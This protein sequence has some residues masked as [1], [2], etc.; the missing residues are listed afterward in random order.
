MQVAG[1]RLERFLRTEF[2]AVFA[3][4]GRNAPAL[5]DVAMEENCAADQIDIRIRFE[6]GSERRGC[7]DLRDFRNAWGG[8]PSRYWERRHPQR[9]VVHDAQ[10]IYSRE[11]ENWMMNQELRVHQQH[12]QELMRVCT[13]PDVIHAHI[14]EYQQRVEHT[15]RHHSP[16]PSYHA[17][18]WVTGV[19]P[20][21][22][23]EDRTLT[24]QRLMADCAREYPGLMRAPVPPPDQY[25]TGQYFTVPLDYAVS[26]VVGSAAANE[27][28][29]QLLLANLTQKQKDDYKRHGYFEVKGGD[30]G[31]TYR[32]RHGRQMNI[33]ELDAG[34]N[35]VT[36]WCFLPQG[37]LCAG[38]C[39]LAQKTA[40]ELYERDALRIANRIGVQGWGAAPTH[41]HHIQNPLREGA[42]SPYLGMNY[43]VDE[44]MRQGVV[45]F[46]SSSWGA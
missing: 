20:A 16:P 9:A 38:D 22:S 34:G 40:L 21:G 2:A 17:D 36:G 39:M 24:A 45:S 8:R 3:E 14:T 23:G 32:I 7:L 43:R 30:S 13:D 10:A 15:R 41:T 42:D 31:K 37:N 18:S 29:K 11:F 6:D 1:D 35:K 26:Q 5:R 44:R 46:D 19:D 27:R 4:H 33:D 25:F 28:G 12:L